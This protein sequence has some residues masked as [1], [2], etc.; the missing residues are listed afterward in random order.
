MS[1]CLLYHGPGA[2]AAALTEAALLGR[3]LCPPLGEDGL[4]VDDARQVVD[5]LLTP[6]VGDQLGVLVVGPIDEANP[7]AADTL[8]KCIE[9]SSG[10]YTQAILWANDLGGVTLTIRSRC[11]ERWAAT[12]LSGED[13]DA[14]M[15]S[16]Y[17]IVEYAIKGDLLAVVDLARKYE[18]REVSLLG[19]LSEVLATNLDNPAYLKIW[20][21][22]RPVTQWKIPW[23]SEVLLALITEG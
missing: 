14:L 4:K 22:L 11:L 21:R 23:M 2:K 1:S 17:R 13:D 15:A 9:E 7:K 20:N 12:S 10:Q 5:L 8:L 3:L 16:A 6:S 19:A 18:K